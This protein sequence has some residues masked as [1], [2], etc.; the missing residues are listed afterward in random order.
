MEG[1]VFSQSSA[2]GSA[3]PAAELAAGVAD[4][5]AVAAVLAGWPP[6]SAAPGGVL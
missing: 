1:A 2:D 5:R 4:P 6:L 3:V